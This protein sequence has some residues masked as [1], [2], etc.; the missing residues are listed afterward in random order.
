MKER[1]Q[2]QIN[3]PVKYQQTHNKEYN[4]KTAIVPSRI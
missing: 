2:M 3:A 1:R 4:K